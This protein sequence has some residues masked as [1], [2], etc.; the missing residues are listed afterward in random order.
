M[1][2]DLGRDKIQQWNEAIWGEIDRAVLEEVGR[3]RV[4]QKVFASMHLPDKQYVPVDELD[5]T[6]MSILEGQTLPFADISAEFTLADTQVGDEVNLRN[7]RTLARAA[8][9]SIALAEDKLF[10]QGRRAAIE[11]RLTV[12]NLQST[13]EGV[14]AK[15]RHRHV[16][17]LEKD[18][19]PSEI[20]FKA[21]T[22]GIAELVHH[23]HPGPYALILD[24]TIFA[25]VNAP[26]QA[27]LT[28]AS[29]RLSPLLTGGLYG[30]PAL[31]E[32]QGL[33]VS[34]GGEP[35]VIYVGTDAATAFTQ[36]DTQGHYHFRVFERVQM[37]VRD[38]TAFVEVTFTPGK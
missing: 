6:G 25:E 5:A 34:L 35:A 20:I 17:P 9:K 38:N 3:L 28:T 8:A 11:K 24:T 32:G 30:T 18:R 37:V 2:I 33:L 12:G 15:A 4:A 31:P 16:V 36:R 21:V 13:G 27:T 22:A 1:L 10:L 19:S 29:E 26:L 7:G 23:G 14:L